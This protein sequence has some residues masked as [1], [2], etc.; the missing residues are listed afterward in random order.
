MNILYYLLLVGGLFQILLVFMI[1]VNGFTNTVF[2][3]LIPFVLGINEIIVA[4]YLLDVINIT[5][6]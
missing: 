4:L 1:S 5:L 6:K 2:F 3:K